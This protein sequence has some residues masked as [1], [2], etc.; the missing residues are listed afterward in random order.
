MR[1][2]FP[3]DSLS[4][5]RFSARGLAQGAAAKLTRQPP[6]HLAALDYV[7]RHAPA[8]D[9]LAA[10][11]ALDAF[12]ARRRFLMNVGP[13]KGRLLDGAVATARPRVAVEC[14]CFVGYAAVRLGRLIGPAG[15]RVISL[16]QDPVFADVARQ[17]IDHAGLSGCV[18]VRV[19]AARDLLAAMS[20]PID[21][22]FLDHAKEA[23]LPDL[24]AAEDRDLLAPG[25]VVV[26]DNVGLFG[27][28]MAAY[29]AHVRA[30]YDSSFHP[31]AMEY[32]AWIPDGVEIS[33][34][35]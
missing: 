29:L 35:R 15:G 30:A 28:A 14:G 17:V 26:A 10:L 7:R 4:R 8:G 19:G 9:P 24:R 12:G 34:R 6:R 5:L 1:A 2:P 25:A 21:L 16:E 31:A 27:D 13:V 11:D 3:G 22:L 32:S 18:E 20:E 23:Y 33:V